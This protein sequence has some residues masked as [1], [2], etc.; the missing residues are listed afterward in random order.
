[1]YLWDAA[2]GGP[3][4]HLAGHA[5]AVSD[6]A[7]SPDGRRLATAAHPLNRFEVKVWEPATGQELLTLTEPGGMGMMAVR[8]APDGHALYVFDMQ[9]RRA[10]PAA[11]LPPETEAADVADRLAPA[12]TRDE[13]AAQLDTLGLPPTLRAAAL[14]AVRLQ[15]PAA[16]GWGAPFGGSSPIAII[17]QPGRPEEEYRQALATAERRKADLPDSPTGW[18]LA[19]GAH[20]RLGRY[21]EALTALTKAAELETS[22]PEFGFRPPYTQA[23]LAMTYHRLN[24]P[25]K[26][27]EALAKMRAEFEAGPFAFAFGSGPPALQ[28]VFEEAEA[29]VAP[30]K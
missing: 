20:F 14:E 23:F 6:L 2:A 24:Q 5:G 10:F 17:T 19:G 16:R 11:P 1:V 15:S 28:A 30:K 25:A 13:A 29:L 22:P 9:G 26:A 8:F 7:F 27:A 12:V 3:P 21:A 4:R 18:Y